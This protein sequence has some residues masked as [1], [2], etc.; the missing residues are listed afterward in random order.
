MQKIELKKEVRKDATDDLIKLFWDERSEHISEFQAGILLD[1]M[2]DHIGPYIYNQAI[3]DAYKLMSERV[4]D[5]YGL[6]KRR[7]R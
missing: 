2:I 7:F 3:G 5:L 6:E 1:F 4:E